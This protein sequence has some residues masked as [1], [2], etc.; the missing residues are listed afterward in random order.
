MIPEMPAVFEVRG[1]PEGFPVVVLSVSCDGE[2]YSEH[3]ILAA[4][5]A[6]KHK[7][8]LMVELVRV[9]TENYRMRLMVREMQS[10]MRRYLRE[11]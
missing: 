8:G 4:L 10:T 6:V 3:D 11:V 5:R 7:K 9:L 2:T 1:P